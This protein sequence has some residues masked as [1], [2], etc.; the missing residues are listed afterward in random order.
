ML[1]LCFFG[2]NN[3]LFGWNSWILMGKRSVLIWNKLREQSRE[4]AATD[5]AFY[6]LHTQKPIQVNKKKERK[7]EMGVYRKF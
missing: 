5:L 3:V 2:C 7:K 6:S 4:E 1:C